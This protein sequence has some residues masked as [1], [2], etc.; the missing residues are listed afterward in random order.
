MLAS[1]SSIYSA[2]YFI[3]VEKDIFDEVKAYKDFPLFSLEGSGKWTEVFDEFCKQQVSQKFRDLIYAFMDLSTLDER[4]DTEDS[5]SAEFINSANE[6]CRGRLI[7]TEK[8]RNG[9]IAAVIFTIQNINSEKLHIHDLE[10]ALN[11]ASNMAYRDALTGVKN[12]ACFDDFQKQ[13]DSYIEI[14]NADFAVGFFDVNGLKFVNDNFGHKNGDK[15]LIDA[16]VCIC[17]AFKDC[18]VFRLGGDEFAVIIY[19]FSKKKPSNY[20]LALEGAIDEINSKEYGADYKVS[21]AWGYASYRQGIDKNTTEVFKIAD[22]E[23]YRHKK[24][25]KTIPGND[26]MVRD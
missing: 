8:D 23:M 19:N 24:F 11:Q 2:I 18:P 17:K 25:I 26:W 5:L 15:L 13:L 16:S 3:D 9:H 12:K 1:L 10:N 7:V 4:F 22:E 6:W 20:I 21:I 14:G